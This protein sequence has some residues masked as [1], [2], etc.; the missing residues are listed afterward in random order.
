M[1]R[2]DEIK[3]IDVNRINL[4]ARR[5]RAQALAD[6]ARSFWTWAKDVVH[7]GAGRTA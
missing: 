2:N 6:M 5:L 3:P 7:M 4:E 1:N